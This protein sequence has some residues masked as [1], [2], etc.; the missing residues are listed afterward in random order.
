MERNNMS[1]LSD[2][3]R[4]SARE[5]RRAWRRVERLGA[6][7]GSLAG[8]ALLVGGLAVPPLGIAVMFGV[9]FLVGGE[10]ADAADNK[11]DD[12]PRDDYG[13]E[14]NVEDRAL[15][16]DLLGTSPVEQATA[17]L[18]S[19]ATRTAAYERAMVLAHERTLGA[20][21]AGDD[22]AASARLQEAVRLGNAAADLS[23]FVRE[24][25]QVLASR[26]EEWGELRVALANQLETGPGKTEWSIPAQAQ[27]QLGHV[28][29]D[30]ERLQ[31]P[32]VID[33]DAE[34][35]LLAGQDPV[36]ALAVALR[37]AGEAT[38]AFGIDWFRSVGLRPPEMRA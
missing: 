10:L 32:I 16:L 5:E 24:Y 12:P 4:K 21:E 35:D 34:P 27:V 8:G 14:T 15:A 20:R 30:L 25:A 13:V 31:K 22:D 26:L 29:L 9:A 18:L 2:E 6:L 37:D 28:G 3:L 36:G 17:D 23:H 7:G 11:A 1:L 33:I 38:Y 19:V